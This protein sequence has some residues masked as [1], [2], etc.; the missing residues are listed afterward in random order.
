[1]TQ[2]YTLYRI[3]R[4]VTKKIN[5]KNKQQRQQIRGWGEFDFQNCHIVLF[6]ISSSQAKITR[7]AKKQESRTHTKGGGREAEKKNCP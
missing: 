6:K 7:H 4:K 2:E 5:N 3:Y 1:M